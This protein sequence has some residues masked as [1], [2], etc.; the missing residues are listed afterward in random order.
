MKSRLG[1]PNSYKRQ[2]REMGQGRCFTAQRIIDSESSYGGIARQN[3]LAA[4]HR[5]RHKSTL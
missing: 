3:R 2:L 5:C 4:I 1:T